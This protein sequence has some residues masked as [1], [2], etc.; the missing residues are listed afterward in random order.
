MKLDIE[1]HFSINAI[2]ICEAYKLLLACDSDLAYSFSIC[3]PES[4]FWG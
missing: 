2:V 3:Q 1:I 4:G